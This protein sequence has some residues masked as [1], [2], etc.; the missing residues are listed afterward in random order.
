[1]KNSSAVFQ[2]EVP[3][4]LLDIMI[5]MIKTG[6]EVNQMINVID[7]AYR[8]QGPVSKQ[9]SALAVIHQYMMAVWT[10]RTSSKY[11]INIKLRSSAPRKTNDVS[12]N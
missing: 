10:S 6:V 11:V 1:M 4:S 9:T 5:Q 7:S 2:T 3:E 8:G 12:A